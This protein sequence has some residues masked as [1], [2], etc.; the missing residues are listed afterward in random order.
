MLAPPNHGTQLA[1]WL[2]HN[3][4]YQVIAGPAGQELTTSETST[5]NALNQAVKYDVGIIAGSFSFNPLM[6]IF[7]H[8]ENDGKVPISSTH[9]KGMKDFIVLPVSHMFMMSNTQV[10][11]EVAYFLQYGVFDRSRLL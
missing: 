3:L 7:F 1:D 10:I 11:K 6:K 5:P 4:I 9:I 2:H 8:E